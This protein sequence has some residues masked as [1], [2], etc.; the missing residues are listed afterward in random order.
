VTTPRPDQRY[1]PPL[2]GA[3]VPAG[4]TSGVLRARIVIVSGTGGGVFIYDASN[5][6]IG[7]WCGAATTDPIHGNAVPRGILD[8]NATGSLQTTILDAS[9]T[10]E[11]LS[12]ALAPPSVLL[13]DTTLS[14]TTPQ[15]TVI[16]PTLI[17]TPQIVAVQPGTASTAETFHSFVFANSWSQAAGRLTSGYFLDALGNVEL[18]GSV[19]VPAGFA[20][21]QAINTALPAA[22]R[23]ASIQSMIAVDTSTNLPVRLALTTGGVLQFVGPTGNTANGNTLDLPVHSFNLTE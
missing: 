10:L 1:T 17:K 18:M 9:I 8:Q 7:S 4:G 15:T 19:V 13:Q 11:K 22:Y 5:N 12:G 21:N 2:K 16:L 23:P 6:L 14:G 3:G 20:A